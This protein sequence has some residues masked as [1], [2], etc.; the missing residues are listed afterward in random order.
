MSA[1]KILYLP[2]ILSTGEKGIF[3][4]LF[5]VALL[6]GAL[7]FG[8]IYLRL[9]VP[10]HAIGGSYTEGILGE[11]RVI[12]PLFASR[13]AERDLSRL[14]FSGLFTYNSESG[15]TGD[16][17]EKYEASED[18]KIY[19]VT[20]RKDIFWHDGTPLT[21]DD[22]AFTIHTIQNTQYKSPLRPNWQG[23]NIEVQDPLTVRFIL[24]T[25]YAPFIENLTVG[26]IP[27]HI[28]EK[29]TPERSLLHEQALSPIGSGPYRFNEMRQ[30]KDGTI[31]WYRLSRNAKY[32]REGPYLASITFM[33]Y[34]NEDDM[35]SAVRTGKIDGYGPISEKFITHINKNTMSVHAAEMPRIFGIFFNDQKAAAFL[36]KPVRQAIEFALNRDE[37]AKQVVSGGSM[38]F[39]YPLP[40]F[41]KLHEQNVPER[42][43]NTDEAK[44]LLKQAGWTD[45]DEDGILD[46]KTRDSK[47]KSLRQTSLLFNLKTSD[48]PDLVRT[49]EIIKAELQAVG[50]GITIETLPFSELEAS[51]IRPRDFE[52][53]LFGQVYGHE[54]DPFPFWHSSQ[55]KDP[56]LNVAIYASKKADRVLEEARKSNDPAER[57]AQYKEF[58]T[59]IANDIPAVFLYSQTFLYLLPNDLQ[60]VDVRKLSLPSDRFNEVHMWFRETKRVFK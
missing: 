50:I 45:S 60:G 43:F 4:A 9:T 48:W 8:K 1:K 17:A 13:D 36:E 32:H 15:I 57:T 26:I 58:E 11:P 20:L 16:L 34:R 39:A 6:S 47:T 44:R 40:G 53:L 59:I 42:A 14:I 24:R 51:V 52:I 49:A 21:A 23:V 38:P 33:F 28:W 22:V 5:F 10:M 56:G 41:L 12:N 30:E 55:I 7:F 19:T 3:T 35:F 25:P 27:K 46:K 29:I 54:P 37:I 31:S 2:R 18:G